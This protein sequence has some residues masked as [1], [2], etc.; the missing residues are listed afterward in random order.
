ME[1]YERLTKGRPGTRWE[2]V[3]EKVWKGVGGSQEEML[4]AEKLGG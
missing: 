3:A 4:S 2:S 1:P